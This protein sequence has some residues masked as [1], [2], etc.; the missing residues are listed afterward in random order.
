M[1]NLLQNIPDQLPEELFETL[2]KN[3]NIHI[4]RIVSKGHSSPKEGWYDQDRNEWV[5]VLKGAAR[6]AFE[7][8][9][10]VNMG[11]GDS[12]EIPAHV[13]HKV[14]WTDPE[15]ETVWVGVHYMYHYMY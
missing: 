12:L 14:V 2:V 3:E 13:K 9:N 15:E 1:K 7:D 4:E 5:L 6:L 10:E 8:G 11:P